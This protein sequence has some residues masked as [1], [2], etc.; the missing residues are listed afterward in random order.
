[1]KGMGFYGKNF[2]VILSDEELIS[3]S[4]IRIIMTNPGE[5]LGLPFFGAGLKPKLFELITD[6]LLTFI[7]ND[8][9]NQISLYEPRA[10]QTSL[11]LTS[12][13]DDNTVQLK[14]GYQIKGSQFQD[15][16]F[17]NLTFNLEK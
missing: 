17:V 11:D 3:E 13:P 14:L 1:M 5:R 10:D 9:T 12:A 8:I 2:L 6:D 15:D 7:K 16:R 4:I